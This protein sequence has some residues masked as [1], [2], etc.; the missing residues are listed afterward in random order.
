MELLLN[1]QYQENV[2][3]VTYWVGLLNTVGSLD[4]YYLYF[5]EWPQYRYHWMYPAGIFQSAKPI[6]GPFS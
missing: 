2:N 1:E 5:V 3:M 4:T 6:S